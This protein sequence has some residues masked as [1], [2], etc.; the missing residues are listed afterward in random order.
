MQKQKAAV[1][2]G[3]H[4]PR[5]DPYGALR[6]ANYRRYVSGWVISATG[7]NMMGVAVGWE[8]YERTSS[9]LALGI[10]G[11]VQALPVI[12]LALP[13]GHAA[14]SMDRRRL[15]IL[16]QLVFCACGAGLAL[17]SYFH[18]PV[19]AIYALLMCAGSAKAFNS[20]GRG[21]LF[22][23][24]VPPEIF[25]N[26]VAWNSGVFHLAAT[27]GPALGGLLIRWTGVAWPVYASMSVAALAFAISLL[28]VRPRAQE[29]LSGG[30]TWA[31]LAAGVDFVRQ[32]KTIL[33]A[34]TLDLF[35]VLLG[36]ATSL[37]PMYAKDILR[38]G[39]VG[40]GW[41][42]AAPYLG[43]MVM[44][45]ALAHRRPFRRAGPALLWAVAGFGVLTI[46]FGL[47]RWF[48]LS[49]ACLLAAG[50]LDNISVVIRHVLVQVRTPD[51]LRGRVT[52]VNVVF[53]ESSNELGGFE[54]GLV[55]SIFGPVVSV[56]SGGIG[57]IVVVAMIAWRWPE[58]R[59][60][61]VLSPVTALEAEAADREDVGC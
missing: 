48:P 23:L 2:Q 46:V 35:A 4:P 27:V 37:M 19:A 22:P 36:G 6:S 44:A 55:A 25:Q 43:A 1:K 21:S 13:A 12:I 40:L 45:L 24:V 18:A 56:V 11:L 26:A 51:A 52:A 38:V 60:L 34:I 9:A 28:G 31:S 3:A 30:F 15:V 17:V 61:G 14:D 47:S 5:H 39:P 8:I 10:V 41:L 32:E 53:I 50:A 49:L 29:R 16:T 20:P 7:M 42:R 58:I 54:S 59:R 57:T 33:S